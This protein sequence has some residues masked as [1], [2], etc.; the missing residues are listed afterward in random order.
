LFP[1]RV[2]F[3][4]VSC[5]YIYSVYLSIS[6]HGKLKQTS[7]SVWQENCNSIHV[8]PT[9]T[10]HQ[11]HNNDYIGPPR[12][13]LKIRVCRSRFAVTADKA[14][15][16]HS[17]TYGKWE[18]ALSARALLISLSDRF[19]KNNQV[20]GKSRRNSVQ[21]TL[22]ELLALKPFCQ[23]AQLGPRRPGF[24][25]PCVGIFKK[26]RADFETLL[27]WV[28]GACKTQKKNTSVDKRRFRH[29]ELNPGLLGP[30]CSSWK[31]GLRARNP[32]H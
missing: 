6:S 17:E 21:R 13:P 29:G 24:N 12:P 2:N 8:F 9:R 11:R 3:G 20:Q 19:P 23:K 28:L 15:S 26:C 22:A 27:P 5:I 1:R 10:M 31:N 4:I 18:G 25:D 32:S 7:E 14:I 30:S 16:R